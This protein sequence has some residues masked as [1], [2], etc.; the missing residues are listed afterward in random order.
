MK[1]YALLSCLLMA[2]SVHA[3]WVPRVTAVTYIATVHYAGGSVAYS[4]K[5]M[6]QGPVTRFADQIT[7]GPYSL[8]KTLNTFLK[9]QAT[10]NGA[11]FYSGKVTGSLLFTLAPAADGT[12]G[13]TVQAPRYQTL[14]GYSGKRYGISFRCTNSAAIDNLTINAQL[15][16]PQGSGQILPGMGVSGNPS[17][18]TDCDSNLGWILPVIGDYIVNLGSSKIDDAIVAGLNQTI[19]GVA[20]PFFKRDQNY[21]TALN[22]L[23]PRDKSVSL[24]GGGSFP[25]GQYVQDNL[26]YLLANS[27]ITMQI[28]KGVVL[29]DLTDET[30]WSATANIVK[31]TLTSPAI[32][33]SV[34]L[35]EQDDLQ[36]VWDKKCGGKYG[37]DC[38]IP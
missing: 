21:L 22:N 5:R 32:S 28:D 7:N 24:P 6:D 33:F 36:W 1:K 4:E 19:S 20:T 18:S 25:I 2:G 17:S 9:Q 10:N 29:S 30:K 38:N 26:P 15:G 12:V 23:I 14:M 31:L 37:T 16:S 3:A 11:Q 27:K 8:E 13:I 34:D 35:Q